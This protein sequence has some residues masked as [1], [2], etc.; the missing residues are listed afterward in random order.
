[1]AITTDMLATWR[2]PA[3]ILRR[4]LAAGPREDRALA[5]LMVACFLLFVAQWPRLARQAHV[6]AEAAAPGAEVPGLDALMGGNFL[7]LMLMAPLVFYGLAGLSRVALRPFGT[8]LTPYA[9][10]ISL[11][12]ALL[13]TAPLMLFHGLLAGIKGPGTAVTLVGVLIFA[14]F[15]WLW[16]RLIREAAR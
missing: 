6:S 3:Q 11:F 8:V 9:A 12:W 16:S 1:M 10:R 4:Q 2:R 14:A 13:C 5:V 15:L 7:A